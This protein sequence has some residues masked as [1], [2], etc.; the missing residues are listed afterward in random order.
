MF[1][2][3]TAWSTA[4]SPFAA[5]AA[6]ARADGRELLD[7]TVANPTTAGLR[8]AP[9]LYAGVGDPGD[10]AYAPLARGLSCA[11]EAVAAYYA[12]RGDAVDPAQVSILAAT[13]EAY[14]D[15]FALLADPG[16]AILVPTPSYP[17]LG[18]IADLAGVELVPYRLAYDGA[19]HVD[20]GDLPDA[21]ARHPRIR[22]IVA[23]APNNPTGNYLDAATIA[24]FDALAADRELAVIVDEVFFDYPLDARPH[25]SPLASPRRALTFVLSGLSKVA[26][27][28][29]M[30]LAWAVTA[31]PADRVAA[32]LARLDVITDTFLSASTPIQ[33]AAPA[34]LAAAPAV[35]ETIRARLRSNLAALR[36]GCRG[37]ALTP[38]DVEGGWT[39]LLRL[40]AVG[41]DDAAWAL[42]LLDAGVLTQPGYLYDLEAPA[43]ALSLLTPPETFCR[44]VE[45]VAA[46]ADSILAL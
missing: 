4:P 35:Q 25:L 9:A 11:R 46:L 31:G 24:A 37:T 32:A 15:L 16:D 21:L 34:L 12:R 27:L 18:Y 17:L 3:R 5:A 38:N 29:Q 22:A 43:L 13:S 30:K 10:A 28:P 8:H 45:R 33:R 41:L 26:A 40:P 2:R 44:G 6:A 14:A 1:S 36:A 39:A 23:V 19:W 7:L 20:L 42:R